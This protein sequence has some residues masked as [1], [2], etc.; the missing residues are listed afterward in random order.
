[1]KWRSV[2]THSMASHPSDKLLV[3]RLL[4]KLD[5]YAVREHPPCRKCG[6]AFCTLVGW[7]CPA[8]GGLGPANWGAPKCP[9]CVWATY[10]DYLVLKAWREHMWY[11]T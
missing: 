2:S 10:H 6:R 3:E 1:M 11:T 5:G 9:P 8:F 4:A 7:T